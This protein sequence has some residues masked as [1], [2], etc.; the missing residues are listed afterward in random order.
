MLL[1][2]SG[3][4]HQLLPRASLKQMATFRMLQGFAEVEHSMVADAELTPAAA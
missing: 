4:Q 3:L 2:G 1:P